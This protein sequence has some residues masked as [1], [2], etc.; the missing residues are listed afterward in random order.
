[1]LRFLEAASPPQALRKAY[2]DGLQE[3][4]ELYVERLV[5]SGKTWCYGEIAYA[6]VNAGQLVEFFAATSHAGRIESLFDEAM[7]ASGATSALCKSFNTQLLYAA[8]SRPVEVTP[9]GSLFRRVADTSFVPQ[10]TLKFR[11]GSVDD[12]PAIARLNDGFFEGTSEILSYAEAGG[13]LVLSACGELAGCGIA[14]PVIPGRADIDI[15]MWAAPGHRRKGYGS[16]IAA[17]LKHFCL[18]KGLRPICGCGSENIASH[19]ALTAAGFVC[20]HR[21]LRITWPRLALGQ[22]ND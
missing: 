20:E 11:L 22:R 13:L 14:A 2:L 3:P 15:G 5:S 7:A 1:M 17:Y 8:L 21:L 10:D 6:V 12:V 4:Q 9:I 16:H 19:R 18:A